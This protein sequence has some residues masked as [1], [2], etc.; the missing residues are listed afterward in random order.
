MKS[1]LK[2]VGGKSKL[3]AQITERIPSH[4]AYAEVFAGAGWVFFHKRESRVEVLND[5]NGELISFYRVLQNHLEEFCRQF[6][7]MLS[8]R[9]FFENFKK[10]QEAGGLTDI[11]RAV[12]FYYLQRHAFGGNV[13][14]RVFG[15]SKES[16]PPVNLMRLETEL[17]E[18]H[19]RLSGVT[20][21][22]LSWDSF[23]PRY[24][25]PNAFFYL[26]PPYYGTEHFYGK[27]CFNRGEFAKMA[28]ALQKT[29]GKFLLSLNDCKEIRNIFSAFNIEATSTM[30][31]CGREKTENEKAGEVF[32]TNYERE[33]QGLLGLCG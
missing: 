24:D 6:K 19:F 30:Y 18:V 5:I 20:I 22:N 23:I 1:P 3:A 15:V 21:E 14:G 9:E 12:R 13:T 32:I 16:P 10:Q 33:P 27:D 31:C 26:D 25:S 8:S 29:E 7:W 11:Q 4:H 28:A 17:S 2:W